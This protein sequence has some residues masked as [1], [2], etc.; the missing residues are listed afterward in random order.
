MV[1]PHLMFC[2]HLHL[3]KFWWVLCN[4]IRRGGR[5]GISNL[6]GFGT[7]IYVNEPFDHNF[8]LFYSRFYQNKKVSVNV[9]A[10]LKYTYLRMT[11]CFKKIKNAQRRFFWEFIKILFQVVR[12]FQIWGSFGGKINVIIKLDWAIFQAL[13]P[14]PWLYFFQK[15]IRAVIKK[16]LFTARLTLMGGGFS[17]F[18]P[19]RER[20]WKIWPI[21]ALKFD[22][23]DTHNTCHLIERGFKNSFY[24][25]FVMLCSFLRLCYTA[26]I[27]PF[28][29]RAAAVRRNWGF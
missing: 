11:S 4:S 26:I 8:L 9:I 5:G 25:L 6:R 13:Q 3:P 15:Y 14:V 22:F 7:L 20:M 2:Y 19:D 18:G 1:L 29:D 21:L 16:G 28:C 12:I 10:T 27:Q 17:L 24:T 23:F